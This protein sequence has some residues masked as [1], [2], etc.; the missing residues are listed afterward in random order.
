MYE[1]VKIINTTQIEMALVTRAFT[2]RV[3][4]KSKNY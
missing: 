2:I 3:F 4:L 1:S